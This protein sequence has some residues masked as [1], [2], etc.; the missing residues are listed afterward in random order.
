MPQRHRHLPGVSRQHCMV[1]MSPS[2]RRRRRDRLVQA[3][4]GVRAMACS[5]SRAGPCLQGRSDGPVRGVLSPGLTPLIVR[6]PRARKGTNAAPALQATHDDTAPPGT[7]RF[8]HHRLGKTATARRAWASN[9]PCTPLLPA[10]W[11]P[12]P[13]GN[14]KTISWACQAWL[15]CSCPAVRCA[16][17]TGIALRI[18]CSG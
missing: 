3:A 1:Q 4:S 15:A 13:A 8:Y 17:S 14:I 16:P 18:E 2:T 7:R 9:A 11:A 10:V 6:C 5:R 12:G